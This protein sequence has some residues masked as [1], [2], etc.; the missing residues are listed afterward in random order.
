MVWMPQLILPGSWKSEL[1]EINMRKIISK[2][3]L[4]QQRKNGGF[5]LVEVL[6]AVLLL[7]IGLLA[8][9]TADKAAQQTQKRAT[10]MS[11]AR[12]IAQSKIEDIRSAPID[13]IAG[14]TGPA[15]DANLPKGNQVTTAVTAYPIASE[16][17][18]YKATV[19]ITWPESNSTRKVC[20]ETLITRK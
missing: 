4:P 3:V 6:A 12:N 15:Q 1:R 7:S 17:D 16:N 14:T 8:V 11:V 9:L 20:Y 2:L 18:L 5:T 13:T 19:T 10:N